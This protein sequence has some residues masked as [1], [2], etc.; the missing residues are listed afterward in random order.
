ME[1]LKNTF[2]AVKEY[3]R[4]TKKH[5][6]TLSAVIS[7]VIISIF[8]IFLLA[9]VTAS[10]TGNLILGMIVGS[11]AAI[12]AILLAM[13]LVERILKKITPKKKAKYISALKLERLYSLDE[14]GFYYLAFNEIKRRTGEKDFERQGILW[15]NVGAIVAFSAKPAKS[16]SL[17][18]INEAKKKNIKRTIAV[19]KA[20]DM[21]RAKRAFGETVI[22]ITDRDIADNAPELDY[23]EAVPDR[24]PE[25]NDYLS[26]GVAQR[27]ISSGVTL[28]LLSVITGINSV[29][30]KMAVVSVL[31]GIALIA[32]LRVRAK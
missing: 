28:A 11:V 6:S 29:F 32:F 23:E 7:F 22:Y 19:I 30:M 16:A 26:L 31:C 17:D 9:T 3:N 24:K 5:A 8:L 18:V 25:R 13:A 21:K 2:A 1:T 14:A 12:F 20:G 10:V 4:Y 15:E 27:L